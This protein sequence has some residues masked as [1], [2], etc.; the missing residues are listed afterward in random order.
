MYSCVHP[1]IHPC[2]TLLIHPHTD[3]GGIENPAAC[4]ALLMRSVMKLLSGSKAAQH[5][6]PRDPFVLPSY[7]PFSLAVLL[8]GHLQIHL[9]CQLQGVVQLEYSNALMRLYEM[10][11]L[12]TKAGGPG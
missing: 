7:Q 1:V 3:D 9:T 5:I 10:P 6:T 12:V 8:V 11:S 4:T 2:S